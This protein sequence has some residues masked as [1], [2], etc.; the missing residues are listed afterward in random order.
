MTLLSVLS[1]THV[2]CFSAV[3]SAA[4]VIKL[5]K[6][7]C[8]SNSR[9]LPLLL[10]CQVET[11]QFLEKER[12][13]ERKKIATGCFYPVLHIVIRKKLPCF[14]SRVAPLVFSA[15]N[16]TEIISGKKGWQTKSWTGFSSPFCHSPPPPS[17]F[18]FLF[19]HLFISLIAGHF[20]NH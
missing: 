2:F 7:I 4:V 9:L 18:I 14:Q 3:A 8:Q 17:P 6:L 20:C 16:N 12:E 15:F 5:A 19:N 1:V 11:V 10:Y 13:R